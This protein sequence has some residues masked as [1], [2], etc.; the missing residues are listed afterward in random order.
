MAMSWRLLA[1][2]L[3]IGIEQAIKQQAGIM[4]KTRLKCDIVD[5]NIAGRKEACLRNLAMGID[6]AVW[7][8]A[9]SSIRSKFAT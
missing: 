2:S 5:A 8:P 7:A 1:C 3:P 4:Q 6:R 9:S